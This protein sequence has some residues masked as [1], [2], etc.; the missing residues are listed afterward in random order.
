MAQIGNNYE[1]RYAIV[2]MLNL[3]VILKAAFP[4]VVFTTGLCPTS[5]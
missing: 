3:L 4:A 5:S 2:Q 1:R